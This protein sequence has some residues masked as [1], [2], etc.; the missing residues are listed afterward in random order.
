MDSRLY[1]DKSSHLDNS[2]SALT[3]KGPAPT[4]ANNNKQGFNIVVN[5][6]LLRGNVSFTNGSQTKQDLKKL[7]TKTA[8][9]LE[10]LNSS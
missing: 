3:P 8:A 9:N 4:D 6:D 1:G 10:K 2:F 5:D 7:G